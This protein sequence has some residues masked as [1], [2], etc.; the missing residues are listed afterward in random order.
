MNNIDYAE[1]NRKNRIRREKELRKH[2]IMLASGIVIIMFLLFLFLNPISTQASDMEHLNSYKYFK[3]I[4]VKKG[5][6]L[7]SIASEYADEHYENLNQYVI[8]VK[9]MNGLVSDQINAGSCIIVPY[10]SNEFL[11]SAN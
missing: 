5:D 7:W 4:E 10:Y 6:S 8:E 9:K 11:S 3:S 1:R 2:I